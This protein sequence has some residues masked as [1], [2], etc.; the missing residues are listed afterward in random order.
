MAANEQKSEEERHA[1][2][3]ARHRQTKCAD[4]D[5]AEKLT[6]QNESEITDHKRLLERPVSK[7]IQR[8]CQCPEQAQPDMVLAIHL[9]DGAHS[10]P[11]LGEALKECKALIRRL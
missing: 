7:V 3:R 9:E 11:T 10:G 8:Y 5:L 2:H 6:R 4:N 1:E